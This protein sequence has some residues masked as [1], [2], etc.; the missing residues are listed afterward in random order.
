MICK[1]N[2]FMAIVRKNIDYK[3][4]CDYLDKFAED[5]KDKT[6]IVDEVTILRMHV[7][8]LRDY[9]DIIIAEVKNNHYNA[10]RAILH[11]KVTCLRLLSP[12]VEALTEYVSGFSPNVIETIIDDAKDAKDFLSDIDS[13]RVIDQ[14]K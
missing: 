5:N 6:A 9:T 10:A 11:A 7:E 13:L 14:A 1:G 8:I 3:E 12:L 4:I 2:D